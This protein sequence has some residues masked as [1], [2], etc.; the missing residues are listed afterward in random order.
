MTLKIILTLLLAFAAA[1]VACPILIRR[2]KM[3]QY[4]QQIREDGPTRH[5]TKAGTPTMGGV[6]ILLTAILAALITSG[7]QPQ[8]YMILIVVLG[9]GLIGFLDDYYKIAGRQSLGLRARSK[10]AG[11]LAIAAMFTLLIYLAGLYSPLV[12]IPF[13]SA[14][15]N[16][17][18]LY[19]FFIFLVVLSATNAVNLTDG[20]D[21]LAAGTSI[22]ALIAFLYISLQAGNTAVAIF[23]AALIGGCLGFLVYNRHPARLFMGD[24]GSFGLGG[25]FAAI[26]VL[27]KTE[28]LLIII[29]GIFVVEALS[30]MAQV[31]SF[32]LIGRRVLLMSP[33]H[34]HFELK[35]WSEWRVVLVFWAAA[36]FFSVAGVLAYQ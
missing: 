5:S 18:L 15:I 28:L 12:L 36:T 23:S 19:P 2:M 13:S 8:F 25:A 1:L 20:V 26:A 33:L 24:V 27:T 21:G 32:Q 17:G 6:V 4:G 22:I 3:L 30:V 31:L 7:N 10:L 35:G 11:G 9:C 14:V 16:L 29:G 34:H